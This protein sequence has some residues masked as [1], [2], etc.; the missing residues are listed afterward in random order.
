MKLRGKTV[1]CFF[2]SELADLM[3]VWLGTLVLLIAICD[4]PAAAGNITEYIG[5]DDGAPVTGPFPASSASQA[6]FEAAAMGIA[7]INTITFETLPVGFQSSFTA[8]SGVTVDVN[9]PNL[10]SGLSGINNFTLGNTNGFNVT[11]NGAQWLG[12]PQGSVTIN[13]AGSTQ[14][15]GVWLTGVQAATLSSLNVTFND[16]QPE[17]LRLSITTNG[18]AAFF[19]FTDP[20]AAISLITITGVGTDDW[21]IDDVTYNLPAQLV[22]PEP[23]SL[24]LLGSGAAGIASLLRRKMQ[25]E[26]E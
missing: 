18:G 15:F 1:A 4:T 23:S 19:G 21:G 17:S 6:M 3:T 26:H 8:A 12:F 5:N 20:G 9:A 10:G 16:G 14:S 11:P 22:L 7:S 2:S 13:F 24:L 25:R